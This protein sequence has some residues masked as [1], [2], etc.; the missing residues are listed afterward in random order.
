MVDDKIGKSGENVLDSPCFQVAELLGDDFAEINTESI[1]DPLGQI[2]VGCA[3]EHLDIR[4]SAL[5]DGW[6]G[7]N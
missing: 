4:H 3:A 2:R 1:H 5:K 6:F 7:R